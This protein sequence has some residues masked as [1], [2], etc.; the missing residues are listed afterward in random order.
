VIRLYRNELSPS[1]IEVIIMND[2]C[3]QL[4]P[5]D[6]VPLFILQQK[7]QGVL[8]ELSAEGEVL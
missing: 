7:G 8:T 5:P 2:M 6:S 3:N 4:T 1:P